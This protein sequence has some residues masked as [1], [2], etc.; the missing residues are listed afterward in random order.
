M[1]PLVS[2]TLSHEEIKKATTLV[3]QT[4]DLLSEVNE[5]GV[6]DWN[7]VVEGLDGF[8]PESIVVE[9]TNRLMDRGRVFEP[10]LGKLRPT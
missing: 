2:D 1:P 9:C 6:A 4:I 8:I 7:D 10:V 3:F 5:D